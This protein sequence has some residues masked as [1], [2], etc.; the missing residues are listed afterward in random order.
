MPKVTR[1]HPGLGVAAAGGYLRLFDYVGIRN[2]R[3]AETARAIGVV[4]AHAADWSLRLQADTAPEAGAERGEVL[5]ALREYG[6]GM[7][8]P[9]YGA[10]VAALLA[11]LRAR[12]LMPVLLPFAPEDEAFLARMGLAE[13]APVLR[14]WW[15]PRRMKQTIGA[16]GGVISVGR[17]HPLLFA[18]AA[19][20]PVMAVAPPVIGANEGRVS[21]KVK[22]MCAELGIA[23]VDTVAAALAAVDGG[24]FG[25]SDAGLLAAGER[26]LG[27]MV[28]ALRE[29]FG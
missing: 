24:A 6:P 29:V 10:A 5:V 4:A 11:G 8:G 3:G 26:R 28:E 21:S 23:H 14:Q 25:V 27:E 2:A 13:A 18:A 15:N 1:L 9:D 12:G 7:I 19:R 17:L 22:T 16:S 20:V